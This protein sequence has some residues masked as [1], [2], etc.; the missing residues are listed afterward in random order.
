MALFSFS[1][2]SLPKEQLTAVVLCCAGDYL[3]MSDYLEMP[4]EEK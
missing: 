4:G 2:P 1:K 3:K